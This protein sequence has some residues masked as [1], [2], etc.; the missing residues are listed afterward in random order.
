MDELQKAI[1]SITLH[2]G[3]FPAK[4]PKEELET[5]SAHR[6]EA[7][8]CLRG[9]IEKA[10][11]ENDNIDSEYNLY[12]Y[13]LFLLA[14]FQDRESFPKILELASLPSDTL[15]FLIGDAVTE[16]LNDCLFNTYNG[17]LQLLKNAIFN[18]QADD[19]ARSAMLDVMGQLYLDKS[20]EKQAW[21]D[22]LREIVYGE[23]IGDYIYTAVAE[24]ICKCHFTEM[25]PELRRLYQDGRVDEYAIGGY[26]DCVDML[27]SYQREDEAFCQSPIGTVEAMKGWWMFEKNSNEADGEYEN[28]RFSD[29]T[30]RIF[31]EIREFERKTSVKIGRN[32]PCPC[33]SGKKYKKCCL[34]KVKEAAGTKAV[35]SERDSR[36]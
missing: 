7:I 12:F 4:F 14:Q 10:I 11:N 17:D 24:I 18:A 8:P 20:L 33:G 32:D 28:N 3:Q 16:G 15:D 29:I 19:F 6:D 36:V 26:D 30:D 1:E 23:S 5:I 35:E 22:F 34:L 2:S 13:A 9:A 31:R 25:I 21:Q 27:F